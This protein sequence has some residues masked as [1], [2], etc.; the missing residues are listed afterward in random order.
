MPIFQD[1]HFK[2]LHEVEKEYS[3]NMQKSLAAKL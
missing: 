1:Y 2:M 3:N